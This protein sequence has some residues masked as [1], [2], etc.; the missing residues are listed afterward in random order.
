MVNSLKHQV[1]N[2]FNCRVSRTYR[3]C[4]KTIGVCDPEATSFGD[5]CG[6]KGCKKVS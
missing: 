1:V 4:S 6:V 2:R 5:V 3:D